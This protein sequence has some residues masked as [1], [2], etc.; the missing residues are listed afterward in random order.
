MAQQIN[1]PLSYVSTDADGSVRFTNRM[2]IVQ[3]EYIAYTGATDAC[4]I[5]NQLGQ[6]VWF[7]DGKADLDTVRSGRIGWI[8]GLVIPV[9]TLEGNPNIPTG[10]VIIYFE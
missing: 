8:N 9:N 2:K 3:V 4:E 5:Q 1:N 6:T 7:G 10:T